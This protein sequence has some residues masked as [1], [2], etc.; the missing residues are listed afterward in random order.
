MKKHNKIRSWRWLSLLLTAGILTVSGHIAE[1]GVHGSTMKNLPLIQAHAGASLIAPENTLSAFMAARDSGADGIETDVRMTKDGFLVLYHN[2]SIEGGSN[3]HGIISEMTLA[4]L[5]ALDFGS[6]FDEQYAGEQIL[7]LEECLEAASDLDFQVVN[8]EL[9]PVK[10]SHSAYVKA[11]ADTIRQSDFTGQI[12]VSSFDRDL[13]KE[14]KEYAPEITAGM[15]TIPNMSAISMFHLADYL[16]KDKPLSAY[17]AEDVKNL[18]AA[19]ANAFSR[20]GAHGNSPEEI[21]L[22]LVRAVAAVVPDNAVWSDVEELIMEQTDLINFIDNLD[23]PVEY[24]HCHYNTLSDTL[25]EAMHERGIGVT[26]WTPDQER[27]IRKALDL[28]VDGIITNE[29]ELAMKLILS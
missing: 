7:T 22:E 10:G 18:P 1:T 25:V 2:D 4:E 19:I 24:L 6:W 13:L 28:H 26:V 12:I 23:F 5:K 29:P 9:K 27:D 3:G 8:L 21:Y 16:P 11:A 17:T 14:I 20:F 15:I